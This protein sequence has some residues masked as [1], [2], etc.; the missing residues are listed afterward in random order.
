MWR[1]ETARIAPSNATAIQW[2]W[3]RRRIFKAVKHEM[4]LT[5]H[6]HFHRF[7]FSFS[8]FRV[9]LHKHFNSNEWRSPRRCAFHSLRT[10]QQ[11]S[12][13]ICLSRSFNLHAAAVHIFHTHSCSRSCNFMLLLVLSDFPHTMCGVFLLSNLNHNSDFVNVSLFLHTN[14]R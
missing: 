13:V 2:K 9:A 5:R 3:M 14:R 11:I 8:T 7:R 4:Q 1:A 6:F 10:M 12:N